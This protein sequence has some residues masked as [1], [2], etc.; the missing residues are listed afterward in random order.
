MED[1]LHDLKEGHYDL[2]A[3]HSEQAVQLYL[4]AMILR[5]SGEERRGHEI[6]E[7]LAELAFS[8]ELEGFN[9]QA[10]KLKELARRYRRG[11]KELEEAYYEAR[12]KPIPYK[13]EEAEELVQVAEEVVKRLEELEGELWPSP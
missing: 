12:Y 10:E 8:L 1:A 4:K 7:L 11:L 5:L 3:F 9:E 13:R 6:R 2:A